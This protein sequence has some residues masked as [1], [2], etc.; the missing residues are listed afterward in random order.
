MITI[1]RVYNKW[2]AVTRSQRNKPFRLRQDFTDI[3]NEEFYPYLV[4]LTDFFKRHPNLFSDEFFIAPFKLFENDKG[5]YK[6]KFYASQKGL[7]ACSKYFSEID[8][9]DAS[10]QVAQVKK[11]YEY[12]GRFCIRHN[13]LI[14][15]YPFYK[16][17]I[18]PEFLIH[19]KD[20][21]ISPYVV[22]S[23]PALYVQMLALNDDDKAMFFGDN[24]KLSEYEKKNNSSPTLKKKGSGYFQKISEIVREKTKK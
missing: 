7:V 23:F 12:I 5:Y 17:G 6:L 20:H 21:L 9:M 8:S 4:K 19:M 13:I 16:T 11:S 1:E 22:F 3:E 18:Y 14:N 24:F 15:D 10:E 2:L